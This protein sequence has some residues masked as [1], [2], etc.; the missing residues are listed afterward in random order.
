[1]SDS[2]RNARDQ[3]VQRVLGVSVRQSP[4]RAAPPA[5]GQ[6]FETA[7]PA[8]AAAYRQ[9]IEAVDRQI[10]AL[11]NALKASDFPFLHRIADTGLNAITGDHKVPVMVAIQEVNTA[12][13]DRRASVAAKAVIA[14]DAFATHLATD[15]RVGACDQNPFKVTVT[16]RQTLGTALKDLRAVLATAA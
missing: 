2:A 7:W 10:S 5:R 16:I 1:M 6:P 15:P 11:Q 8:A 14:V 12:V 9:A 13:A 4:A 3:W